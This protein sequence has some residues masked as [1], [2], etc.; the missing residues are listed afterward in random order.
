[1]PLW[2]PRDLQFPVEISN[3]GMVG[4]V[5][6][7]DENGGFH[8]LFNIFFTREE[9]ESHGYS[10]PT[11]F[12]E[13]SNHQVRTEIIDSLNLDPSESLSEGWVDYAVHGKFRRVDHVEYVYSSDS[14][15][16]PS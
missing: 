15:D 10:P 1:M 14:T 11:N 2:S 4:D 6:Y 3:I 8:S 16:T 9:N 13:Y 5:G 7:F 12:K